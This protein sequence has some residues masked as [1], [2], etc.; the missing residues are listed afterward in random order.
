MTDLDPAL[1]A[2]LPTRPFR[3]DGFR[4]QAPKYD[5]LSGEGARRRGGRFNPP[6][7]FPVLY[8]CTTRAC[9]VAE[10]LRAG[11]RHAI[12]PEGLLPRQLFRYEVGLDRIVDLTDASMLEQLGLAVPDLVGED[13]SLTRSIGEAAHALGIQSIRSRSATEQDDVLAVF[14]ENLGSGTLV[15]N[16][17]ETWETIDDL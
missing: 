7:S 5:P 12:G 8:L 2:K 17:E 10:F 15:A 16:L 1:V 14:L 9:T 11:N 4:Q 6:R 13:L 3:G